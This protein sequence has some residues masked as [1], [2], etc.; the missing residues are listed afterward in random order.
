MSVLVE[1]EIGHVSK[2]SPVMAI[3]VLVSHGC[4]VSEKSTVYIAS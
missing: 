4:F 3:G 1:K 2:R